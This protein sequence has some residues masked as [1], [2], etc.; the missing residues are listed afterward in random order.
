[1][2]GGATAAQDGHVLRPPAARHDRGVGAGRRGG[3]RLGGGLR[4][5]DQQR[6]VACPAPVASRP[7]TCSRRS[8]RRS[9]TAPTRSSSTSR[10][11][12]LT[13]QANKQAINDSVKAIR[14]QPHVYSVTNPLSSTGQTAG[15]LSKDKQTA[16]APVL[17]DVS[18]GDL[19]TEMAQNVDGRDRAGDEG[20]HHHGGRRLDRF[21]ALGRAVGD[22]RDRRHRRRDDHLEL[23]ARQPG[24]DGAPDHHGRGG[25][26]DRP[27]GDRA[28]RPRRRHP[29]E[30]PDPGHHDRSRR[31][32]RLRAVHD[33]PTSGAAPGRHVDARLHRQR[34]R[35]RPAARSSSPA[36]RS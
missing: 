5:A 26:R 3:L 20:R 24:G 34:G 31:R 19:T 30:R 36:A 17:M 32:H 25:A 11:G 33:H 10:K 1:M 9:R 12:K 21:D 23:R 35:R 7:R 18:S 4:L 15:L 6:P 28:R 29:V 27:V 8:S 14:A 16:F 2:T 22:Q 13:D